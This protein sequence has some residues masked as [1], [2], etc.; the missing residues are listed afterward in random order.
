[1]Q[2]TDW[3][4]YRRLDFKFEDRDAYVNSIINSPLDIVGQEKLIKF[5]EYPIDD[6]IKDKVEIFLYDI[7][8][9]IHTKY[10]DNFITQAV[11]NQKIVRWGELPITYRFENTKDVPSYFV[12]EIENAFTEWEKALK[13]QIYFNENNE[14][15]NIII[16]FQAIN[17]ADGEDKK[18]VVAYTSI[19]A[20]NKN[21]NNMKIDFYLKDPQKKYFSQNQVYN[22][23]L[24]EIAHALGFMGHSNEEKNVMYLTKDSMDI[25]HDRRDKLT[26]A[27]INTIKLLYDI[28]PDITNSTKIEGKYVPYIIIGDDETINIAKKRE[29]KTYIKNAPTLPAGWI[30]LAESYASQ[31]DFPNAIRSLEKALELADTLDIKKIVFYNLAVCYMQINNT[32]MAKEYAEKAL[33]INNEEDLHQI[34]AEVYTKEKNLEKAIQKYNYL[35]LKNPK[36]INYT[37][38]LTNIYITQ[39]KYLEARKTLKNYFKHNP[40]DK[41]N[42][43]LKSYGILK[44]FL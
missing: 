22:T 6:P 9:E 11:F 2:Y 4:G 33:E 28:K 3:Y 29:A 27:D 12:K 38:G 39:K 23:A 18:Y 16:S 21:L 36:N 14:D 5:L 17:P 40:K 44:I 35:I 26:N 30:D 15:A 19:Q 8:R 10:P 43:R 32:E 31:E 37:I 41:N 34:L 13:H 25:F 42:P 1:M 7:K 20:S 24:H